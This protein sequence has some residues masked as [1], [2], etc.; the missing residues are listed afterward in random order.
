MKLPSIFSILKVGIG[1]SSSHTLG[2]LKI[3]QKIRKYIINK[4]IKIKSITIKLMGSFAHTGKGH[5]THKAAVAGLNGYKLKDIDKTINEIRVINPG[6]FCDGYLAE[7]FVEDN[8][9]K[10]NFEKMDL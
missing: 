5:L 9:I 6:A 4:N 2:A 7:I 8:E 3:G 10:I 1:P